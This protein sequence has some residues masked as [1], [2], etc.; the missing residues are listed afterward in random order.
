MNVSSEIV[1]KTEDSKANSRLDIN[2]PLYSFYQN[3]ELKRIWCYGKGYRLDNNLKPK[4]EKVI[5]NSR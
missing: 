1:S 5:I 4:I 3:E 2:D